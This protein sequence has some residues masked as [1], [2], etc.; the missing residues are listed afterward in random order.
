M[1]TSLTSPR[2]PAPLAAPPAPPTTTPSPTT[3]PLSPREHRLQVAR[4]ARDL[5]LVPW[6]E[7]RG[8]DLALYDAECRFCTAQ[9]QRLARIAGPALLPVPLQREGLLAALGITHEAAMTAMHLSTADG[10]V[11]VGLEAIVQS[12]R[13]RPVLGRLAKLY[14]VPGIRQLGDLLYRLVARYRYYIMGR[15]VARGE[16]DGG[17]CSVHLRPR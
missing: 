13:H 5:S 11:F 3:E 6:P 4:T 15:A 9:A 7:L 8:H 16:C 1:T 12:L 17:S 10:E 14:Y 2:A